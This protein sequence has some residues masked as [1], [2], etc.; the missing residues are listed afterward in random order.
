MIKSLMPVL[1]RARAWGHYLRDH[2][3]R[4]LPPQGVMLETGRRL[5]RERYGKGPLGSFNVAHG[6]LESGQGTEALYDVHSPRSLFSRIGWQERDG[7][8]SVFHLELGNDG[9]QHDVRLDRARMVRSLA[10]SGFSLGAVTDH[11]S[12]GTVFE[13]R[14]GASLAGHFTIGRAGPV[15]P[16]PAAYA[17]Q[18]VDGPHAA[19]LIAALFKNVRPRRA[20][21]RRVSSRLSLPEPR[22]NRLAFVPG[23]ALRR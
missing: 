17:L 13:L 7:A 3:T 5:Y 11:P 18:A 15:D 16:R 6:H 20:A 22:Q 4:R 19:S 9:V 10:R 23:K 14:R 12:G 21:G 8:S 1:E 2:G